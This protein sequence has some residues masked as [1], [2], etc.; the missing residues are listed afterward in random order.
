[1]QET[2]RAGYVGFDV[3][4]RALGALNFAAGILQVTW[5][6]YYQWQHGDRSGAV[7]QLAIGYGMAAFPFLHEFMLR[8]PRATL[9]SS[10]D[11]YYQDRFFEA[12]PETRGKVIV[13]HAIEQQVLEKYPGV[14][15]ES[16][17]HSLEN[18]RGI[19]LELNSD[20]HLSQI[21]MRWNDFY[22]ANPKVTPG[23]KLRLLDEASLIDQEFGHLFFPPLEPPPPPR[24]PR[25]PSP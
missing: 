19:P 3:V 21:R 1:V 2:A 6:S 15:S 17:M 5:D 12:H 8:P 16:E 24:P 18:L 7:E 20:I 11:I 25:I 13:H 10:G 4:V 22:R 14:I 9:G 23:L